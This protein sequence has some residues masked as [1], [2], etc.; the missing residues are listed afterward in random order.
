MKRIIREGKGRRKLSL[1]VPIA[2]VA[3]MVP[4]FFAAGASAVLTTSNPPTFTYVNDEN[5]ADD[6]PGQKDLSAQAVATP[7]PGDLWVSWKWDVTSLSGSNTGDA[8]ALFDTNSNFK[9]NF[10]IC[11]TISGSPATQLA[12]TSPRVY[13]CGDGKVDRCTSTVAQVTTINSACSV[14]QAGANTTDPFHSGQQDT[15]AICH[16]DLG[17]VGGAGTANL[18]NTCS[19]PSQQPNSDPSDCVLIPRDA[20]ITI[21]KVASPANAGSFPFQLDGTTVFTASGSQTSSP[22]AIRSDLT[23]SVKEL[24]PSGWDI[25]GTPSCTGTSGT[26]S[27]NGTYSSSTAT[28]SGIKASSDN[29]V[30]CTFNDSQRASIDISK[31]G[32]DGGAQTGAVFTLYTAFG[33]AQQATVAACTVD[34][35]GN[36]GPNDPSF[37][38]LTSGVQ[39]TIDETTV[40]SGY[41]KPSTL[42]QN[43]TLTAGQAFTVSYTDAAQPGSVSITKVDDSGNPVS[44]AVFKLYSPQGISA[45]A[46]T[47]SEV[48]GKNCT[49]NNLGT[50]TISNVSAGDYT[51]DESTV[52]SGYAKDSNY[53]QNITVAK[54]NTLPLT[55][56]DPE[57]F[58]VVVFVCRKRDTSLYAAK[59]AFDGGG[60][61]STPNSTTTLPGGSTAAQICAMGGAV[62]DNATRAGND[63]TATIRIP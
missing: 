21:A 25:T 14:N 4:L 35:S 1:L 38:N 50:C 18:V 3:V 44:G 29:S 55:S 30:T 33:T 15:T 22:I 28:I 23:H 6:Q 26:G 62:H 7:S 52:P 56:T 58:K 27:S 54:G 16:V 51:I 37:S 12:G 60:V 9:V 42:P 45:G 40:P 41:T 5:G 11:V 59:V 2:V 8:C 46:P 61:P 10:A 31:A 19:Y 57:T 13:T 39:Y 17:D 20:F 53:P 34:T 48:T 36:C 24:V 43:V 47:G 32:S 49:T 63:H